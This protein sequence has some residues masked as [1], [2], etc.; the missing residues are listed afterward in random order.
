MKD[1]LLSLRNKYGFFVSG[2]FMGAVM[3][4]LLTYPLSL[5]PSGAWAAPLA[6]SI[7]LLCMGAGVIL[8]RKPSMEKAD[9]SD[10]NIECGNGSPKILD[11]SVLID[12]RIYD[13]CRAGFLEGEM[14]LPTFVLVELRHIADSADPLR[15]A[16][17]RRGLDV[18]SRLREEKRVDNFRNSVTGKADDPDGGDHVS[19]RYGGYG[20]RHDIFTSSKKF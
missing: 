17:G 6:F 8:C 4:A 2:L 18:L 14:V 15:R 5:L 13:I 12:G 20:I 9:V 7:Y 3:A 1:A 11:T 19:C 10:Y 16:R